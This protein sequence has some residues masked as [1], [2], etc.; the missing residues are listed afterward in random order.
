MRTEARRG[1]GGPLFHLRSGSIRLGSLRLLR[2]L[3]QG[4]SAGNPIRAPRR[5][6]GPGCRVENCDSVVLCWL[7]MASG[8]SFEEDERVGLSDVWGA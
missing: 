7:V 3:A 5:R 2:A 1:D 4:V 6:C 8:G